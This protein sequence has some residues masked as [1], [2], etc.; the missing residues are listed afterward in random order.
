MKVSSIFV[1]F[2]LIVIVKG[3]WFVAAVQPVILTLGAVLG[4]IDLDVLDAEP[5]SLS[6]M[7]PFISKSE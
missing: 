1:S 7:M 6:E 3:A 4:A 2:L 5:I